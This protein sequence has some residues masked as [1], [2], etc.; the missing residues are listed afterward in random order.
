MYALYSAVLGMG[1]LA[2]LPAFLTRRRRAGYGH[3]LAQR[4]GRL[5]DGLPAEPRC[6]IHAV[7]VGESAAAVPLV[8]AIHR[9]WPELGI[10]V[11]TITPTGARIVADRLAGTAVHRYFPLD[12]PGS[13]RRALEAA[14]P[15]FFIAIETELW[16]NF[17]RGL[18]RRR[19]PAMIANGRISDRSFRRYLRVRWLMR[20][21]L[22]DV[23]VFAMQS[24][25]DARRIVA[26]GA[27][28]ERV[29]VTG[30]L[31]S[32]LVPEADAAATVWRE[33][34][35]L[36]A[37]DRLWIAGSTHRGEEAIVLDAFLRA[38]VRCPDLALLL[39]PRHP[40]RA[41]EVEDL[42]R[43]R[44]L[45]PARW[46]RLPEGRVPGAVVILD[47]V[48]ELAALYAVAEVV[49]VGGSLVPVGGH[50]VLEPAMRGKPVLYGPH[51]SN[52]REGAL[53]LERCGGGLV[54]EDGRE[55]ARELSRL[56]EDRDLARRAGDAARAAFAGRQGAVNATLDL[57][58]RHLWRGPTAE[59]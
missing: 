2:Y 49:F 9:R 58:A 37:A 51:T 19:I 57:V 26:L 3:D 1:L 39:A 42:I 29:V 16:P 11:S 47:T 14:R 27:P 54:V 35:G 41:A 8:E 7:S 44:G 5:G 46:S 21:V 43:E 10:V 31:K 4:F 50:N 6:W 34:L 38:R 13:V 12:L 48:G 53:L 30:N 40:E 15:R 32:D 20:R 23:S 25:E 17:L 52:F 56:L 55:L 45:A 36:R 59:S 22:A 28:A 24:E 33:R 18:A